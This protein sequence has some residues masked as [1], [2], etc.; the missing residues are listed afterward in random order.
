[1]L[2]N[3]DDQL[4]GFVLK[5]AYGKFITHEAKTDNH[6]HGMSRYMRLMAKILSLIDIRNMHL[7]NWSRH[8]FYS[9]PYTHG[10]MRVG[11]SLIHI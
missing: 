4:S 8:R 10:C 3:S 6:P 5:R 1:M 7:D 11:L 9:I 2:E